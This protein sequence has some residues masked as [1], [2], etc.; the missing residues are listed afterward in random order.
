MALLL[1]SNQHRCLAQRELICEYITNTEHSLLH[2]VNNNA[3]HCQC[4]ILFLNQQPG[5]RRDT[6]LYIYACETV[7][8]SQSSYSLH[9]YF[10]T[11]IN[12]K[13]YS[14]DVIMRNH[15]CVFHMTQTYTLMTSFFFLIAF[16]SGSLKPS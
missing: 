15:E 12:E 8:H 7:Y 13:I 1:S 3:L 9:V 10:T 5:K 2:P 4:Q 16:L 14:T 11:K 6:L